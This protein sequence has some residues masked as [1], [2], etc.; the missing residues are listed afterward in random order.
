MALAD[1]II[2][3]AALKEEIDTLYTLDMDFAKVRR[4]VKIVAPNMSL[5]DWNKKYGAPLRSKKQ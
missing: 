3:A 1:S 5:D 2:L 4:R